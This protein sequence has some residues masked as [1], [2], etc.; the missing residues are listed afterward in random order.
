MHFRVMGIYGG[1]KQQI[2]NGGGGGFNE[3]QS[4]DSNFKPR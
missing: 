3:H 1:I 2:N 4:E